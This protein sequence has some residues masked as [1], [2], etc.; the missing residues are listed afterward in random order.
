MK[1]KKILIRIF[2][3]VS[4]LIV[5]YFC[6]P[7]PAALQLDAQLPEINGINTFE[8]LLKNTAT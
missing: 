2:A 8:I 7:I 3:I 6:A 5:V 1:R 4:V